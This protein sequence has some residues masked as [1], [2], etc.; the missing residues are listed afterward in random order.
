MA[1]PSDQMAE[2]SQGLG[3]GQC[4][5]EQEGKANMAGD[6]IGVPAA[7]IGKLDTESGKNTTYAATTQTRVRSRSR[8]GERIKTAPNRES[9]AMRQ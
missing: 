8:S 3:N 7:K 5:E 9:E 2:E 4:A 1:G 6:D